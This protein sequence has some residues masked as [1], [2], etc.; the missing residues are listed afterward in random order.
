M[1]LNINVKGDNPIEIAMLLKGMVAKQV[2]TVTNNCAAEPQKFQWHWLTPHLA[3]VGDEMFIWFD[4]A[5][6]AGGVEY[7]VEAAQQAVDTHAAGLDQPK[8]AE[9]AVACT[10]GGCFVEYNLLYENGSH[11]LARYGACLYV[12]C[13]DGVPVWCGHSET[14]GRKSVDARERGKTDVDALTKDAQAYC[15]AVPKSAVNLPVE[16]EPSALQTKVA[17]PGFAEPLYE[18]DT[19]VVDPQQLQVANGKVPDENGYYWQEGTL[20]QLSGCAEWL[21]PARR[22]RENGYCA[23]HRNS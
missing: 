22:K 17:G 19:K 11:E 8:K 15:L 18:D 10:D 2:E 13:A 16:L 4:E 5:G 3:Q 14:E 1:E 6:Q 9:P 23:E 7:S 20:C 21:R 12:V